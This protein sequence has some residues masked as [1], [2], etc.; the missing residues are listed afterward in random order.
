MIVEPDTRSVTVITTR[1]FGQRDAHGKT[2]RL[3]AEEVLPG[4]LERS[5]SEAE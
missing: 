2:D 1:N 4:L 5:A 3:Y